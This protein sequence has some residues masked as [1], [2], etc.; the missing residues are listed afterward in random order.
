MLVWAILALRGGPY[1]GFLLPVLLAGSLLLLRGTLGATMAVTLL[2]AA[3]L[4]E[5]PDFGG[6]LL[7]VRISGYARRLPLRRGVLLRA[8]EEPGN[9]AGWFLFPDCFLERAEGFLRREVLNCRNYQI[10]LPATFRLEAVPEFVPAYLLE[11]RAR[12]LV[13]VQVV[14]RFTVLRQDTPLVRRLARFLEAV[15]CGAEGLDRSEC[16]VWIWVFGNRL[17]RVPEPLY[18]LGRQLGIVHL[19]VPSGSQISLVVLVLLYFSRRWPRWR[20]LFALLVP[21]LALA[22]VGF[23]RGIPVWR[24]GLASIGLAGFALFGVETNPL[25]VLGIAGLLLL[26]LQPD[27]ARELS[28]CLSFAA[29]GGLLLAVRCLRPAWLWGPLGAQSLLLPVLLAQG[30]GLSLWAPLVNLLLYPVASLFLFWGLL[31]FAL[32]SVVPFAAVLLGRAL[33]ATYVPISLGLRLFQAFPSPLAWPFWSAE[34]ALFAAGAL[35]L[36]WESIYF[37]W[38]PGIGAFLLPLILIWI[39]ERPRGMAFHSGAG[40]WLALRDPPFLLATGDPE[41]LWSFRG[42]PDSE[43]DTLFFLWG[44][45]PEELG[46]AYYILLRRW[47]RV[48]WLPVQC[49]PQFGCRSEDDRLLLQGRTFILEVRRFPEGWLLRGK[50]FRYCF[51][52]FRAGCPLI[53]DPRGLRVQRGEAHVWRGRLFLP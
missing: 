6:D 44:G 52:R 4:W 19:F 39:G 37:R 13:R 46:R 33:E 23:F 41:A 27:W 53:L 17:L 9:P 40:A 5:P 1:E 8:A 32:F 16:G 49:L 18:A 20:G 21:V 30:S 35:L 3:A 47:R 15:G 12:G 14:R 29:A 38:R 34:V 24:A 10:R 51:G 45:T 48:F 26:F 7:E 36:G 25:Q 43:E 22:A 2:W 11:P 50:D 28:F 42:F 31:A